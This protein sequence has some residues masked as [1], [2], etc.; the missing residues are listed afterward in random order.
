MSVVVPVS[1]VGAV[2]LPVLVG[3]ALL[4]ERPTPAAWV[5]IVAAVPALWLVSQVPGPDRAR[6]DGPRVTAGVPAALVA[7]AGFGVQFLAMAQVGEAA[8]CGPWS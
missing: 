6:S 1:D 2:A 3:V 7:S 4:G 8:A 5:G